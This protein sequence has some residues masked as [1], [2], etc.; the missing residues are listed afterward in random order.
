MYKC[1]LKPTFV[2]SSEMLDHCVLV[3][4]NLYLIIKLMYAQ[5]FSFVQEVS[6]IST[7]M[8]DSQ[9]TGLISSSL[10]KISV[11]F[12]VFI[13]E[14]FYSLW[15]DVFISKQFKFTFWSGI[16]QSNSFCHRNKIEHYLLFLAT[17]KYKGLQEEFPGMWSC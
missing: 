10:R 4:V 3:A 2:A 17:L 16:R 14:F 15:I 11:Q 1:A 12:R 9:F 6:P 5:H 8:M 13:C 7:A